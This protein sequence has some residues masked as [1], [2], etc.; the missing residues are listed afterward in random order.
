MNLSSNFLAFK[1]SDVQ[2]SLV[3]LEQLVVFVSMNTTVVPD[4]FFTSVDNILG[5]PQQMM[6]MSQEMNK[7]TTRFVKFKNFS[8]ILK[9][10][11]VNFQK[12]FYFCSIQIQLGLL[13][14]RLS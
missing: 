13:N 12:Y 10:S 6:D 14:N 8:I 11:Y 4:N 7:T 3:C 2:S 5:V 1:V 9:K